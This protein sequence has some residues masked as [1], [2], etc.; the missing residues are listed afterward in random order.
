MDETHSGAPNTVRVLVEDETGRRLGYDIDL[1]DVIHRLKQ[2]IEETEGIS[3][4]ESIP[5][6]DHHSLASLSVLVC[7]S[8]TPHI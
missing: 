2:D 3:T 8:T 7:S 5:F 6:I 1:T 4:C